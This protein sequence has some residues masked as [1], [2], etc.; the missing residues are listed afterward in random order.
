M[1]EYLFDILSSS[2]VFYNLFASV[3][4]RKTSFRLLGIHFNLKTIL[5][6]LF[7]SVFR[8]SYPGNAMIAAASQFSL[9]L[10][11]TIFT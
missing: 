1:V 8:I 10:N 7:G 5:A 3:L 4:L 6:A 9:W 11:L 2:Y